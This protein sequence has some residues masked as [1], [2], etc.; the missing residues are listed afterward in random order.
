MQAEEAS[1]SLKAAQKADEDH[2][3]EVSRQLK[4]H[5]RHSEELSSA[6]EQAKAALSSQQSQALADLQA[7]THRQS[8]QLQQRMQELQEQ[9][10]TFHTPLTSLHLTLVLSA[11]C[12]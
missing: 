6:L 2:R 12:V 9:V 7:E 8:Q 5:A 10:H 4:E 1:A 11:S 3:L